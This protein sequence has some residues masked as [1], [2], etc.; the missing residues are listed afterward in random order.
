MENDI[1]KQAVSALER[2]AMCCVFKISR[3]TYYY[4]LVKKENTDI[5]EK[6]IKNI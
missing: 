6:T 3:S 5:L 1:L 2:K 4:K